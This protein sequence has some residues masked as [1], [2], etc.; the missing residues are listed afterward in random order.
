MARSLMGTM[1]KYNIY[2]NNIQVIENLYD[3]T[4]VQSC[5]VAAQETG[6]ALQFESDKRVYP[7]RPSLTSS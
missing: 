2:A 1:R 4:R 6:T 5:S 7:H 3:K